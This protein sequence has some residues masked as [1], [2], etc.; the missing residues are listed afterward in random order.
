V[1]GAA[2]LVTSVTYVGNI[3]N[4]VQAAQGFN[5]GARRQAE[6][7]LERALLPELQP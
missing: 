5:A 4:A 3:L 6:R 2:A 7:A 1:G